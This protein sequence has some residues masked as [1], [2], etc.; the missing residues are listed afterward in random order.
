MP[1]GELPA[2]GEEGGIRSESEGCVIERDF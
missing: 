2:R 1:T